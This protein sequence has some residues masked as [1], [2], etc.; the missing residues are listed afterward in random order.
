MQNEEK[1]KLCRKPAAG[2]S[3][4]REKRRRMERRKRVFEDHKFFE[5]KRRN[6]R[7]LEQELLE[8]KLEGSLEQELLEVKFLVK[9]IQGEEES[10]HQVAAAADHGEEHKEISRL[11]AALENERKK[12][13]QLE[14]QL[15]TCKLHHSSALNVSKRIS[16]D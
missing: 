13:L 2:Y 15:H 8:V 9:T 3:H 11:R 12:N 14:L 16:I 7:S 6:T 4:W 1:L 10:D 5:E